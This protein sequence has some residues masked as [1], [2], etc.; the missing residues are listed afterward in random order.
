MSKFQIVIKTP[1]ETYTGRLVDENTA[2]ETLS[3]LADLVTDGKPNG[4]FR[5]VVSS[6]DNVKQV[7]IP[8]PILMNSV[9]E[10]KEFEDA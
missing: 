6:C 8:K 7:V 3:F 1:I 5:M 4:Y 10:I 2:N 9:V